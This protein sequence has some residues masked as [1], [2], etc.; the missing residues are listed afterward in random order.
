MSILIVATLT[1][2]RRVIESRVEIIGTA[3][4]NA[5]PRPKGFIIEPESDTDELREK[6]I[7]SNKKDG[8]DTP[9]SELQ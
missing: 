5:G 1:F 7:A 3:I 6:I 4:E 2:F 9:I 8:R